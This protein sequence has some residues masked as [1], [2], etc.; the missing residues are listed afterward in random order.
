MAR[1]LVVPKWQDHDVPLLI[2]DNDFTT[3][4]GLR[5][6]WSASAQAALWPHARTHATRST[7]TT[8]SCNMLLLCPCIP[9]PLYIR[10]PTRSP[11]ARLKL[12]PLTH[13]PPKHSSKQRRAK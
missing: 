4:A 13:R 6:R 10:P 9:R 8:A 7:T 3:T 12:F 2:A 1:S 11:P 5:A